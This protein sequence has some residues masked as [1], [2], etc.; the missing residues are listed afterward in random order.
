MQGGN[1]GGGRSIFN[2]GLFHLAF[3]GGGGG[4]LRDS[5]SSLPSENGGST[6]VPGLIGW[7][8]DRIGKYI[9]T[10]ALSVVLI[11]QY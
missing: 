7:S 5:S 6:L 1:S 3:F 9:F 4:N 8:M 11:Y 2:P 10:L